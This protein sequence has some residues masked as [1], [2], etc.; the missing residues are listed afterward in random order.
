MASKLKIG[1][2]RVVTTDDWDFL[3]THARII[4]EY[5]RD[6]KLQ[7][8]TD[9]IDGFPSGIPNEEEEARA[10]P[11]VIE[12]A[13]RMVK[14]EDLNALFVSCAADPGVSELQ[15]KLEIPV[16]GAGRTSA[17]VARSLGFPIGILGIDEKV[18]GVVADALG[19]T[20]WSY[21]KP[22]DVETT[23]DIN[24][25]LNKYIDLAR[26]LV[27]DNHARVILLACTGL[28]TARLAPR[29]RNELHIPVVDPVISSGLVTYYAAR[30]NQIQNGE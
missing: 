11:Y 20:T 28:S 23:L 17:Y 22:E 16:V 26:K 24:K 25:S 2:I 13:N 10:I 1:V 12:T 5:V 19:R 30:G 9:R 29:I 27:D 18:P 6:P 3:R 21:L 14:N 8:V 7:M 15:E 4:S